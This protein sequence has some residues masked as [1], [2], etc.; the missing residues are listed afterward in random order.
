[1]LTMLRTVFFWDEKKS[2][3]S[4]LFVKPFVF[5]KNVKQHLQENA[6]LDFFGMDDAALAERLQPA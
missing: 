2:I 6:D 5:I 3:R 1:M 4:Y